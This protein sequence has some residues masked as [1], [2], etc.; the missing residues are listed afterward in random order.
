MVSNLVAF[1][2]GLGTDA[3]G[4]T[5]DDIWRWDHRR[6]EM[7]HDFIQWLFPLLEPSRFNP[8]APLLTPDDVAAFR[9]D[10][11]LQDRVRRSLDVML[12]FYGLARS[13]AAVTR[14][15]N[16]AARA[17]VWLEATN[18]NHLRLTR[19]LLFLRHAGLAAEAAGLMSCLEHIAAQEGSGKITAR[20]LAF[21]QDAARNT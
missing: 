21:W 9:A 10:P 13:A 4:R 2:K 14:G 19:M 7:V 5:I 6:L 11:A 8:D 12:A 18:H 16:F 20:T 3:A 15:A 17:G 1:Y